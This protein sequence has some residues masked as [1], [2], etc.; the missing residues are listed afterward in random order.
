MVMDRESALYRCPACD[1]MVEWEWNKKATGLLKCVDK[2][3]KVSW[4]LRPEEC[5]MIPEE[6][7]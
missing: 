3:C 7:I 4:L 1:G 5:D 6:D 2:N